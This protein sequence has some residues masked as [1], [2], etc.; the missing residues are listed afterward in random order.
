M[1]CDPSAAPR[2]AR[3]R[4]GPRAGTRG[5]RAHT[6]RPGARRPRGPGRAR[7]VNRHGRTNLGPLAAR[8]HLSPVPDRLPSRPTSNPGGPG[9]RRLYGLFLVGCCRSGNSRA[10]SLLRKIRQDGVRLPTHPLTS[11]REP[12]SRRGVG[13][14]RHPCRQASLRVSL[15]RG[16]GRP[17]PPA[18]GALS[19]IQW[20]AA[21]GPVACRRLG[22]VC[23][24]GAARAVMCRIPCRILC[25]ADV[26]RTSMAR[27]TVLTS[28]AA[29]PTSPVHG[30][31]ASEVGVSR[32]LCQ[33]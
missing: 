7:A 20:G 19:V 1:R 29:R 13:C 12:R 21:P 22:P 33:R 15:Q 2:G 28:Q 5:Q 17:H 30:C 10:V 9:L 27:R 25:L 6:G 4:W 23:Q 18:M 31:G 24:P 11:R 8:P 16:A 32:C 14:T 26:E 3:M